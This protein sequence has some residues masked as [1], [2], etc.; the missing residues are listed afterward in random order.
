MAA[1]DNRPDPDALLARIEAQ[2]ERAVRG[3]LKISFGAC[4]GVGKTY[5]VLNAARVAQ[6]PPPTARAS[7]TTR[8]GS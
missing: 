5:G 6:G 3:K 7:P 4:P 1:D 8:S 2:A